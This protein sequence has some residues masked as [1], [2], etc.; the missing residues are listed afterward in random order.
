MTS[1]QNKIL[2]VDDNPHVINRIVDILSETD[3]DYTFFQANNGEIAYKIAQDKL[4][5]IIITD[6]DMPI[7]NG[8]ELINLL[9]VNLATKEIPIIM[10][11]AVMQ[12]SEDL[13]TALN[14]GAIDYIRKPIDAVE[15]YARVKSVLKISS[16]NKQIIDNKNRE[17]AENALLLIRNNKFNIQIIKTLKELHG[18]L[19]NKSLEVENLFEFI[20]KSIKEKVEV[21]AWQKF[22][23]TFKSAHEDFSKNLLEQFPSITNAEIKL[24]ILLKLG[25]NTKDISSVLFQ[26]LGSVRVARSRLRKKLELD[27]SQNLL[28]FLATL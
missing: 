13:K 8:I 15:L 17:I 2:I 28:T 19:P 26:S 21:D 16:Y 22:E 6:W 18:K 7:V 25:M 3:N 10:A 27:A 24:C 20:I 9:K 23:I 5:D 1:K 11:T 14:A 12:T 4:P